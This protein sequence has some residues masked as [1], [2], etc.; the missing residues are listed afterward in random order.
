[1][2]LSGRCSNRITQ[3]WPGIGGR[4]RSLVC[5]ALTLAIFVVW[6]VPALAS[7]PSAEQ[8][9]VL[10]APGTHVDAVIEAI[11]LGG[12]QVTHVFPPQALVGEVPPDM[13]LLA[14]VLAVHRQPVDEATLATLA[15]PALRAAQV[16]NALLTP[17]E[18]PISLGS[19]EAELV[20]DA[21]VAAPP[22]GMQPLSM[23]LA[24]D[25]YQTSE[26]FI[27]RVAVGIIL[28]ESDGSVDPSTEDWTAAERTQML[29]EITAGLDWWAAREPNAHLTFVYD[30]GTAAPITTGYEPISRPYTDQSLWIAEVMAKKG[31]PGTSYFDQVRSYNNALRDAY[32]TDWAFTI[33]VVDSSSDSDNRFSNG[34]FAYAYL[35]GPFAVMTYGNAAHGPDNVHA[36]ASHEIGHIFLALDQ[37]YSAYQPC[38]RRSG[39][40]GVENQNSQYGA[41]L[42][43]ELSIMSDQFA[44]YRAGA[45]DEYARG[46]LGWRDSDDDGILDPMDTTLGVI[47]ADYV[48]DPEHP[49]VLAFTGSVQD[50]PYPSPLRRSATINTI[51]QVQYRVAGGEWADAQPADGTFDTYL[52][53]FNFRTPPLPTGELEVDL[54]VIDSAGNQ[55]SQAID[56]VSVVDPVDSIL[57]TTLTSLEQQ[58]D[59]GEATQI[60][61][62]GQGISSLSYIAGIYYRIDNAAWQPVAAEDGVFDEAM[63]NFILTIDLTQLAPGEHQIQA[64]SVDGE[65][66]MDPSPATDPIFRQASTHYVFLPLV[67]AAR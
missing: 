47:S 39:Y 4:F 58:S 17:L 30:D 29:G 44:A 26:F 62:S 35:G 67:I 32:A 28:P 12:G 22:E 3:Q 5:L 57:D 33:F 61:Y 8:A 66:N 54:R 21:L 13:P 7:Q 40:L 41:C 53:A 43:D 9:L 65:G 38:T 36:V 24:P 56:T 23:D 20:D 49:N 59:G 16:W 18:A 14:G 31:H 10:L 15:G 50:A 37:Y 27:G 46:Q 51:A 45:V 48:A 2:K 42:S 6:A 1:M 52:E 34:Y 55:L 25:Y 60:F 63:E 19:L 11:H 64:Y